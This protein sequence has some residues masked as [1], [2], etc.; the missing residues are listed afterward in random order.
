MTWRVVKVLECFLCGFGAR[1]RQDQYLLFDAESEVLLGLS[2][3]AQ[4]VPAGKY[5]PEGSGLRAPV[6]THWLKLG[7]SG[8]LSGNTKK[9]K[10]S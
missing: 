5:T 3:T 6:N 2:D 4:S 1:S 8:F 7:C 10:R 9:P